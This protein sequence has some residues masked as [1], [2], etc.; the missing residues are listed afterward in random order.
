MHPGEIL[1]TVAIGVAVVGTVGY[2]LS[3]YNGLVSLKNNIGRSWANIDVLLKQRHDE[4]PKLVKTCEGY[5]QHERAVFDRLSEA[6]GALAR[7]RTI[8]QRAD[9]ESELS[10][11]LSGFFAVAE[12]YPDLKA[13]LSFL[14]LQS[15]ISEIE[16]QIADR[17]EYYND[18]VTTFNTRI[19][20]MPDQF[21]ARW[22]GLSSAQL[23][24]VQDADREDI[25]IKFAM[26]S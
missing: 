11:S 17:R 8:E 18:T 19:Q 21:V 10:R 20:Q 24:K 5:M 25:E 13:N 16:N 23:F 15:R 22:L 6:R 4:L 1:W 9:A 2:G 3:I 26:A 14:Q 12:S 7:A